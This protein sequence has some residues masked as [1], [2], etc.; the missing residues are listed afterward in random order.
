MPDPLEPSSES[1]VTPA[2]GTADLPPP[3]WYAD[4]WG[5][6]PYRWWD[7]SRWTGA[8]S[9]GWSGKSDEPG[10]RSNWGMGD[11]GFGLLVWIAATI[12]AF[13]VLIAAGAIEISENGGGVDP[14]AGIGATVVAGLV[15]FFGWPYFVSYRK[16]QRSLA[17]DFRWKF[18]WSDLGWGV[19]VAL[20][21]F[22][23]LI[24]ISIAFER[25]FPS[26]EPTGN[27]DEIVDAIDSWGTFLFMFA[28]VAVITPVTEEMFFRGL[29]LR[30]IAKRFSAWPAIIGSAVLFGFLHYPG[31]SLA[32]S[33]V[34][35][36]ALCWY[37]FMLGLAAV[38]LD[39]V[40]ASVVAH[41]IVNGAVVVAAGA[42]AGLF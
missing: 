12:G 31:G 40:G 36:V 41:V 3:G 39:R 13:I 21:C 29:A 32:D 8:V 42:D 22:A 33:S 16:G 27:T 9:D 20:G 19:L 5:N 28:G 25:L 18:A 17:A 1:P 37:G 10:V 24:V 35:L 2:G 34:L 14:V 11:I 30:A 15:G 26:I 4:P 23:G 6:A 7:G 38:K